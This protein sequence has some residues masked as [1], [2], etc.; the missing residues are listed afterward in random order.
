MQKWLALA[1]FLPLLA[2]TA[3]R[4]Q[5]K[6]LIPADVAGVARGHTLDLRVSE[7]HG[8]DRSLPLVRGMIAQQDFAP[9]TFVGVG[10][11]NLYGRTKRGDARISEP[12]ARS[13]KPAVTFLLK[14]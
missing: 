10:L 11:A 5:M 12:P 1:V 6:G 4:A 2:S 14:F 3:A 9:N 13:K 7:L 8:F